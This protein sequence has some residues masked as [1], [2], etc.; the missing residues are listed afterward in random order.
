MRE[1]QP[2]IERRLRGAQLDA[3]SEA[4]IAEEL[5]QHLEDVYRERLA[6]GATPDEAR[7]A[8]LTELEGDVV[9]APRIRR[10]TR[11][12][13][14]P[15]AV[16]APAAGPGWFSGL[17]DD[18]RH[19]ARA[20]RRSPVFTIIAVLVIALGIG[21]NT[22]IFS[23]VNALLLRPLPGV[24][25]PGELAAVF[26][27]DFSGPRFGATSYPDLEAIESARDVFSAVA[28]YS[29]NT[30]AVS[31]GRRS[32]RVMGERV[33]Y[34]YFQTL[35]VR[36]ALGR[37][38]IAE[39]RAG[40]A[41][42][43]S[44]V[45]SHA[46][47][48][49]DFAAAP[50]AIGAPLRVNG[51]VL[52]I[53]G[54][55][56]ETFRGALRGVS[57]ELWVPLSAPATLIGF[58]PNHRGDRGLMVMARLQPDIDAA[59]AQTRLAVLAGQLHASYPDEWTD[60]NRRSR[61]LTV[62][63]ES[64]ARVPP[65]VRA[66]V[67]GFVALLMTVVG[68]VLLIAC[69][70]VANLM[71]SRASARRGEMGVRLAL[72]ATRGRIMRHLL[73]ES[74]LLAGLGGAVGVLLSAWLLR[75]VTVARLPIPVPI[76]LDI[77]LDLRVLA[78]ALVITLAVGILFGII[79]ALQSS[80]AP[81]PLL[82]EAAT[83]ITK[84]RLRNALVVVQVAASLVLLIIGGLFLR[85]LLVAQRIDPGFDTSAMA[86]VPLELESE[87]MTTEQAR[88]LT[89]RIHER[90]AAL[91]GVRAVALAEDVPLGL[92]HA[93]RS[94]SVAGYAPQ[95]G[96]DMEV[97]FNGVSAG[98]FEAMGIRL[99]R[100]RS[101]T[102]ADREGAPL[103]AVVNEA[104]ARRFWP[105]AD[106]IGQRVSMSGSEG[107]FMEVVGLVP[108]GKYISLTEEPRPYFYYPD[109]QGPPTSMTLHLRTGSDLAA[110]VRA[111]RAELRALVPGI[112]P[113]EIITLRQHLGLLMM[114]QRIAAAL[115]VVLGG[116]A[117]LVA[118]V[119]LYGVIAY[120]VAQRTREF[121]VRM[122]LG[123]VAADVSRMVLGQGL[124]VAAV[125]L[126]I[127][128]G[129]AA[130]LA[131]A[132]RGFLFVPPFDIPTFIAVPA[133]LAATAAVA[134]WIPARRATRT[135]PLVAIRAE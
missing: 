83:R 122:A 17:A 62:L 53:V 63:P 125:G 52:T 22:T 45:I 34:N 124:R 36:P 64:Q 114:P 113:P 51:E 108:D 72:G 116:L 37:F 120:S 111:V 132:I 99:L 105:G 78:F 109:L 24:R 9:L 14:E 54:V 95:D 84:L 47:W 41:T 29:P 77:G 100:G 25:D 12:H 74:V 46:L 68:I 107:P 49:R 115:L 126:L 82:R 128:A 26:T 67:L 94:I 8:A 27:S 80:R 4:Q 76:A 86:L 130:A 57:S 6:R 31:D 40:R 7:E 2:E 92:G 30:Y 10:A 21:A 32:R 98:Y 81:A 79:P 56:P 75:A 118:A 18:L 44:V 59:A 134:T 103:V 3:A 135:D 133:L 23:V 69:T 117:L 131:W 28:A 11:P 65:Q 121:G 104:F 112:T 93:R 91:P 38:F 127:G 48:Q 101:F 60:I 73:T 19:G 35:G 1:W 55:A 15:L 58:D 66:P 110:V 39:E 43:T 61:V 87:G 70:N 123:A 106:P 129:L 102:P 90:S 71:L 42:A 89:E 97:S 96:E 33:S 16:G 119:G 50:D 88:Q 85:S 20:L 5:A 13:P